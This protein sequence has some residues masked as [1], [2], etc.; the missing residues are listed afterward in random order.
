MQP[1]QVVQGVAIIPVQ[2]VLVH[3]LG[4]V[5]PA[6]GCTGFDGIRHNLMLALADPAVRAIAFDI[7]SQ[8]GEV[9]GLFDLADTIF[10]ARGSKPI[11][12]MVNDTAFSGAYAIA[13]ACDHIAVPRTGGTGSV[14]VVCMHVDQSAALRRAGV[15][16]TLIQY[17]ARKADGS[18]TAP[19]SDPALAVMQRE[20]DMMGE[21]FVSTVARNRRLDQAAVRDTEAATYLGAASVA[22][23]FADAVMAPDEAFRSLLQQLGPMSRERGRRSLRRQRPPV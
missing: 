9:D 20:V 8:G 13:S 3:R 4:C 10:A 18:E 16:V 22:M 5:Q 7:D 21:I 11:W 15:A 6:W 23:G 17:G 12:A 1:C 2:G 19:L 14:G